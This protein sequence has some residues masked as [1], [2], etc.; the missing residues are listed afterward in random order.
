[1]ARKKNSEINPT[2]HPERVAIHIAGATPDR[3]AAG[4]QFKERRTWR[5]PWLSLIYL[6]GLL[7][8]L[9]AFSPWKL[10][11]FVSY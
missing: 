7:F 5:V 8:V 4:I 9:Y 11:E 3:Q 10:E 6:V 2:F 1:M